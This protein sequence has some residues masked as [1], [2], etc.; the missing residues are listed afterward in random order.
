MDIAIEKVIVPGAQQQLCQAA[1]IVL[2]P[3]FVEGNASKPKKVILEVI[4][5][6]SDG[7]AI[8]VGARIAHFVIQVAASLDLKA[9]QHSHNVAIRLNHL[10]GMFSPARF[11]ERNSKSVVSPRSSSR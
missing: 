8:K 2:Q 5:I 9:R 11:F 4:Q 6:P 7:L 3:L 10:G 1:K